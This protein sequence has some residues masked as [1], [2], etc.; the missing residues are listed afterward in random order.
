MHI[1]LRVVM[2]TSSPLHCRL[3][4]GTTTSSLLIRPESGDTSVSSYPSCG[5]ELTETA[6]G[7]PT[8]VLIETYLGMVVSGLRISLSQGVKWPG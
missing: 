2:A 3:L 6:I 1:G 4:A 8:A 5:E 7:Q